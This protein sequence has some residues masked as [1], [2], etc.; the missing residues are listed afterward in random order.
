MSLYWLRR[1]GLNILAFSLWS[2]QLKILP[3]DDTQ[4]FGKYSI[5]QQS[6]SSIA[7]IQLNPERVKQEFSQIAFSEPSIHILRIQ[8]GILWLGRLKFH[9]WAPENEHFRQ[10]CLLLGTKKMGLWAPKSKNGDHFF[11]PTSP[12]NGEIDICFVRLPLSDELWANF[13]T[14]SIRVYF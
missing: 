7:H 12:Q 1:R 14:C 6:W 2:T 3:T 8:S 4:V 9:F 11:T 13:E 10:K 5:F